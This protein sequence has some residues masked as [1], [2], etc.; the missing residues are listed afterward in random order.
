MLEPLELRQLLSSTSFALVPGQFKIAPISVATDTRGNV[1]VLGT[2]TGK[3]DFD[4]RPNKQYVVHSGDE[5][6]PTFFIAK[7]SSA[8]V[9]LWV[10]PHATEAERAV[11]GLDLQAIATDAQDNVYL[12]GTLAG[13]F[14]ANPSR[15]RVFRIRSRENNVDE[16]V[17]KLNP[18]GVLLNVISKPDP[19]GYLPNPSVPHNGFYH[20]NKLTVDDAGDVYLEADY[21]AADGSL[22]ASV[23]RFDSDTGYTPFST[24]LPNLPGAGG[25]AIAIDAQ[26]NVG[27]AYVLDN[28]AVRLSRFTAKGKFISDVQLADIPRDIATSGRPADAPT[29][30]SLAFDLGGNALICGTFNDFRTA[31]F[32]AGRNTLLIQSRDASLNFDETYLAKYSLRGRPIFAEALNSAGDVRAAGA[33]IDR[34]GN[35]HVTGS[36]D[37]KADLN[38]DPNRVSFVQ[39]AKDP[40]LQ[41][42]F[43]AVYDANGKFLHAQSAHVT[44]LDNEAYFFGFAPSAQSPRATALAITGEYDNGAAYGYAESGIAVFAAE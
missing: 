31:D 27:F 28:S 10:I 4:P 9:P 35:I 7:Y 19:A 29:L 13:S 32:D 1:L 33:G 21:A 44:D 39:P 20:A 43:S 26:G 5:F 41:D 23:V 16:L 6:S 15:L 3:L 2:F 22:F 38:P 12:S 37:G 34:A 30:A 14:D 36:F 40:D 42:L 24:L 11:Q 17:W 25:S 18:Q 8:G